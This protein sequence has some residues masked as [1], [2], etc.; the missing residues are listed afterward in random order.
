MRAFVTGLAIMCAAPLV[1]A[2]QSER[3]QEVWQ[4]ELWKHFLDAARA[5][6]ERGDRVA[7][8]DNC[9]SASRHVDQNAVRALFDYAALLG[10]L[11]RG[12]AAAARTRA[13][14]LLESKRR[15]GIYLG[16]APADELQAYARVLDEVG[17]SADADAMRA[18]GRAY[19]VSQDTHFR[20]VQ[21]QREGRDPTGVC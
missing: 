18:L 4:P 5:A 3:W 15:R 20:R 19:E 12:D 17:R 6:R 9:R 13:E 1:A 2:A 10:T 11:N 8:E 16:F 21:E 14:R 7:A